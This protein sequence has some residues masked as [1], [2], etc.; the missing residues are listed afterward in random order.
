EP[1]VGSGNKG[2][3]TGETTGSVIDTM[4]MADF[5]SDLQNTLRAIIGDG[6]GRNVVV[7]AQAGGVFAR[8]MPDDL[9]A[10]GGDLGPIHSSAQRQGV[11]EAKII[12]VTLKDGFQA[13]VNWT[14]VQQHDGDT[15]TGGQLSGGSQLG[16][17]PPIQ[18]PG[19]LPVIPGVGG[20]TGILPVIPGLPVLG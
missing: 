9:R 19:T 13:G 17:S 11:L 6:E 18:G 4:N 12:E 2:E 14:A 16:S 15:F 8:G 1:A 7:N 20:P 10:G 3:Q 5:W